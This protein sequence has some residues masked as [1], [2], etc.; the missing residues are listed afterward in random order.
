MSIEETIK[1]WKSDKAHDVV[2][3]GLPTSAERR[4]RGGEVPANALA[5]VNIRGDVMRVDPSAAGWSVTLSALV[6][7]VWYR[8]GVTR[9]GRGDAVYMT[10]T[11]PP[12]RPP[13]RGVDDDDVAPIY[14]LALP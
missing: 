8:M 13:S 10:C 9:G 12:E 6:W 14:R 2:R 4:R 5:D 11:P 3:D 7:L 1:L